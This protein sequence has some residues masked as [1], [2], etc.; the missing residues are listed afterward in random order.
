MN[1]FKKCIL[2][3]FYFL[4]FT[5]LS[6]PAFDNTDVRGII[7]STH[8]GGQDWGRDE[9]VPTMRDIKQ[10]GANWVVIHPYAGISKDGTVSV[11][12]F[13]ESEAPIH[14]TRPIKEAHALGLKISIT[15]HLAYWRSG[16]EWAG[17][18][19]FQTEKEWTHFWSTYRHWILTLAT[20]CKDADALVIGTELDKTLHHEK[21]WRTLIADVRKIFKGQLTYGSNWTD[22]QRVPFWDAL[23]VIGIQAYFPVSK[24]ENPTE[25]DIRSGWEKHIQTLRAYSIKHNRN[26]V[27]TELGYNQSYSAAAEP[28]GYRVDDEGARPLQEMCWRIAFEAIASEPRVLGSLLWKWFPLPRPFGRNFQLATQNIMPIIAN[29]WKGSVPTINFDQEAYERWRQERRNRRRRSNNE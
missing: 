3:T 20:A 6:I 5:C 27:F 14:W 4:I 1:L 18:I 10:L 19:E 25:Q 13:N 26:I 21:E 7:I 28:W 22:Y 12:R 29:A 8:G 24:I 2:F 15:P 11:R 23:D 17:D 9:M 16:F